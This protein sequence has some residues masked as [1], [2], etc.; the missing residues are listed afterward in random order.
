MNSTIADLATLGKLFE[1]HRIRL[2]AMVDRRIRRAANE[3]QRRERNDGQFVKRDVVHDPV[4]ETRPAIPG[5]G[6]G[7]CRCRATTAG[8][9]WLI[10]AGRFRK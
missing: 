10:M 5:M 3:A 7:R 8:L 2:L 6:T 4:K 1:E 9:I